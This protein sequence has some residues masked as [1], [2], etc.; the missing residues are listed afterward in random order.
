MLHSVQKLFAIC[1]CHCLIVQGYL[2][3][4][5]L[6]IT[7]VAIQTNNLKFSIIK[8][9]ATDSVLTMVHYLKKKNVSSLILKKCLFSSAYL[10]KQFFIIHI[11][12]QSL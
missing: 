9:S 4:A 11:L 2:F 8:I 7:K 10:K 12:K 3:S 1:V 6:L 5:Q